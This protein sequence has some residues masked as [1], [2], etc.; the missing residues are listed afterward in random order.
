MKQ[1]IKF[2][3]GIAFGMWLFEACKTVV[4]DRMKKKFDADPD[5]RVQVKEVSPTLYIKYRKECKD[6]PVA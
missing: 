1:A 4:D 3:F 5:F 6:I 2:G